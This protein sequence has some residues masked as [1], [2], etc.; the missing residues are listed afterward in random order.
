MLADYLADSAAKVCFLVAAILAMLETVIPPESVSRTWASRAKGYF[1]AESAKRVSARIL[2]RSRRRVSFSQSLIASARSEFSFQILP[3]SVLVPLTIFRGY[4]EPLPSYCFNKYPYMYFFAS[5]GILIVFLFSLASA[6]KKS[7]GAVALLPVLAMT[8]VCFDI[9]VMSIWF[10]SADKSNLLSGRDVDWSA[11]FGLNYLIGGR[12]A[13]ASM[14]FVA[15]Y[16][17]S[18]A[19]DFS[20]RV[21]CLGLGAVG[22]WCEAASNI[23]SRSLAVL[24]VFYACIFMLAPEARLESY[25]FFALN[26]CALGT[27]A[28]TAAVFHFLV[29]LAQRRWLTASLGLFLLPVASCGAF[30]LLI[31]FSSDQNVT[32]DWFLLGIAGIP[33]YWQYFPMLG[34]IMVSTSHRVV[35]YIFQRTEAGDKPFATAC[36]FF[37]IVGA[38]IE[39]MVVQLR[40]FLG[41]S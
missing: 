41:A 37:T 29:R 34:S 27:V 30:A 15:G 24:G 32:R 22:Y 1:G 18:M 9:S 40:F 8:W 33:L 36:V 35:S 3:V 21:L 13:L 25:S 17:G 20:L 39:L 38:F 19:L 11:F 14:T 12:A 5:L 7:A 16:L 10:I 6:L 23:T 2:K 31:G 26:L 28:T 4:A